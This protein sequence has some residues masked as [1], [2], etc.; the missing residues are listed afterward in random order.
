MTVQSISPHECLDHTMSMVLQWYVMILIIQHYLINTLITILHFLPPLSPLQESI[1]PFTR[2]PA[3]IILEVMWALYFFLHSLS[4]THGKLSTKCNFLIFLL[5]VLLLPQPLIVSLVL[6]SKL[7]SAAVAIVIALA[8]DAPVRS[9]SCDN[10]RR[11]KSKSCSLGAL[12]LAVVIFL[13][14]SKKCT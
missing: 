5:P 7:R 4:D 6:W 10:S 11:A 2:S 14:W 13:P 9:I 3:H 8:L 1:P 12:V